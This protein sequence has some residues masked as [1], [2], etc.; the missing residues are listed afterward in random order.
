MTDNRT[1]TIAVDQFIAA[2]AA[3]VWRAL[4]EP[5][6]HARWWASRRSWAIDST[7]GAHSYL[8]HADD[9]LRSGALIL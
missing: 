4:T 9:Q 3:K 8:H 7:C 5:E 2:P 1:A 6:S